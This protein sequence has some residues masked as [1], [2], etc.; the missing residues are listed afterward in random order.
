MDKKE[1]ALR[2]GENVR[3]CRRDRGYTQEELAE[4]CNVSAAFCAQIETGTRLMSLS[5]LVKMAEVLKT[6]PG[7]LIHG[8]SKNERIEH[9]A[10]MLNEMTED[11]VEYIEDTVLLLQS[12]LRK[13]K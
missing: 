7:I 6:S 1:L 8:K 13:N 12:W 2:M 5:T 3:Q 10:N 11:E 9:V 4:A